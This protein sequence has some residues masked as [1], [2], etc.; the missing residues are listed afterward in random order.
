MFEPDKHLC[1]VQGNFKEPTDLAVFS[2]LSF[3]VGNQLCKTVGRLS[4][5]GQVIFAFLTGMLDVPN[6][7]PITPTLGRGIHHVLF[8]GASNNLASNRECYE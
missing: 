2:L 7:L 1:A 4:L 3:C 6:A 5:N 8:N